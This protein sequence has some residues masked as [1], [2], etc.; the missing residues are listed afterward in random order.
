MCWREAGAAGVGWRFCRSQT[1]QL[2]GGDGWRTFFFFWRLPASQTWRAVAVRAAS[3]GRGAQRS[4]GGGRGRWRQEGCL[5]WGGGSGPNPD[6]QEGSKRGDG[7]ELVVRSVWRR[8]TG[9]N[10]GGAQGRLVRKEPLPAWDATVTARCEAG[11]F[12]TILMCL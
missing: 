12:A 3:G 1:T 11:L 5:Q 6:L 2:G 9:V 4:S 7:E 10:S 8:D